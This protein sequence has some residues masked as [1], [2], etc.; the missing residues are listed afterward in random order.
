VRL[1]ARH[2]GLGTSIISDADAAA[3]EPRRER[4]ALMASPFGTWNGVPP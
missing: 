3:V 1:A 2:H 4:P